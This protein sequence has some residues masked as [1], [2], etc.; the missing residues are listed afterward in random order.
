MINVFYSG[1][2][3]SADEGK[4]HE[5]HALWALFGKFKTISILATQ[6][7]LENLKMQWIEIYR[8]YDSIAALIAAFQKGRM[9][10]R[11]AEED[12]RFRQNF[13]SIIQKA[14]IVGNAK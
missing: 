1:A 11:S 12:E 4:D 14:V 8:A 5:N 2:D 3:G 13:W 10:M 9:E 6:G 7:I